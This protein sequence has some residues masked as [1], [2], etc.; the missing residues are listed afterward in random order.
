MYV[1]PEMNLLNQRSIDIPGIQEIMWSPSDNIL[2]YWVPEKGDVPARVGLLEIPSQK[3]LR[4][5]HI[6]SVE[7]I[8]MHWQNAGDYLCIKIA[9]RKT[10]K[11]AKAT[12]FEI[13]R[14]RSKAYPVEVLEIQSKVIAFAWEPNGHRFAVIH[15]DGQRPDVSFWTLKRRKLTLIKTLVE[16]P[17]NALYWKGNTI[18]LAGLGPFNGALTFVETTTF[19]ILS[20]VEHFMCNDVEWDDSGRYVMTSVCA[21]MTNSSEWRYSM[22]NGYKMWNAQGQIV[23]HVRYTSG[24]KCYRIAWRPRP[25]TQ[26]TKK[27]VADIR[28]NLRS[29]YWKKFE[30]EDNAIKQRSLSAE[31]RGRVDMKDEWRSYRE[32]RR[33]EYDL[34]GP[35]REDL[36][37]G[38]KSDDEENWKTAEEAFE[39]EI[40][41]RVIEG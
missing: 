24:E 23:A 18:V 31:E 2:S 14:M 5:M 15:G 34:E 3:R 33:R 37:Q 1:L 41:S 36:R 38:L 29:K 35:L 12:N 28:K 9:R 21:D 20:E 27:Q 10:K 11:Q 4:E 32:E 40:E 13:V 26:L 39:E 25:K 6:Y 19:E 7:R 8:H 17:A 30:A 16:R 22:E